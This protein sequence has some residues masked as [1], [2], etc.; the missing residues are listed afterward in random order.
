MFLKDVTELSEL[1]CRIDQLTPQIELTSSVLAGCLESGHKILTAGNG[2]SA[3]DAL[4]LS[5]E[6]MGKFDKPRKSLASISLNA[7]STL[8][9]CISNDFGFEQVFS[10][11]IE[12]IGVEGDVFVA[13]STSGNSKNINKAIETAENYGLQTLALLGKD[14]GE[15][16]KLAK[17]AIVVPSENTA[18]IQEIHT[19]ILHYWITQIEK[20]LFYDKKFDKTF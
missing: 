7:D 19:L 5:E 12:G 4:H 13:F 6:L 10:R 2:G 9:S 20:L 16:L 18:R 8:M 17:Y 11:Q 1:L 15:A 14:G 3:A